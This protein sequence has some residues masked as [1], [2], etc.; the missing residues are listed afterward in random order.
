MRYISV[1]WGAIALVAEKK[2]NSFESWWSLK[3]SGR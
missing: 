2:K 3:S 1:L